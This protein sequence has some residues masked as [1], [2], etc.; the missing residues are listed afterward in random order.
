M[1]KNKK[2]MVIMAIFVLG[3]VLLIGCGAG[4]EEETKIGGQDEVSVAPVVPSDEKDAGES[5][6]I[7]TA[8]GTLSTINAAD[9]T[10]T[11]ATESGDELVL[12]VTSESKILVSESLSTIDKLDALIGSKVSAGYHAETK[13]L[14]VINIQD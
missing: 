10:V 11:I 4:V 1:S 14:A 8:N 5:Q 12:K 9:G 3:A 2:F 7:A 13:T 6:A